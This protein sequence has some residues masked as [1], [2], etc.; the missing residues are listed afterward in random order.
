MFNKDTIGFGLLVGIITPALGFFLV[1]LIK[2]YVIVLRRDDLLYI[3]CVA[4][5]LILLKQ[6]YKYNMDRAALGI[7]AA[8]FICAFVFVFYKL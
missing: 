4:L 6:A 8:S 7:I 1:E 5:N 3:G 2:E